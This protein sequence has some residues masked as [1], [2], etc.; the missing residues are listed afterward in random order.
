MNTTST[1]DSDPFN[2]Q[3]LKRWKVKSNS[4]RRKQ[5]SKSAKKDASRKLNGPSKAVKKRIPPPSLH[6]SPLLASSRIGPL[7]TEAPRRKRSTTVM[8]NISPIMKVTRG[9]VNKNHSQHL[10][11][12]SLHTDQPEQLETR[13]KKPLY[14]SPAVRTERQRKFLRNLAGTSGNQTESDMFNDTGRDLGENEGLS[15]GAGLSGVQP[16]GDIPTPKTRNVNDVN[17]KK[18]NVGSQEQSG[19][20]DSPFRVNAERD[21]QEMEVSLRIKPSVHCT[22][23]KLRIPLN[24]TESGQEKPVEISA[25]YTD[26]NSP[27]KEQSE[28]H[29]TRKKTKSQESFRNSLSSQSQ[30]KR[31]QSSQRKPSQESQSKV[32][33]HKIIG[34]SGLAVDCF[35]QG[36][37]AGVRYYLL[38]HFHRDH[39]QG[40]SRHW[41]HPLVCS[42][43]TRRLLTSKLKVR[44]SLIH[45]LDVGET[46]QFGESL[47]TAMD[48]NHCPGSVM[49]LI[50]HSG[51]TLLHTGDFRASPE[52]ESS[53]EFW[54]WDFRLSRLYLDTTYCRPQYDFPALSDVMDK[55][56]RLVKSFLASKPNTVII[57]GAYDVGKEKL[58]KAV[59]ESLDCKVWTDERRVSTWRC[60]EDGQLLARLVGDRARA[61]VLVLPNSLLTW[62]RLGLE[63]ERLT[64]SWSHVLGVRPTGWSH[65]RGVSPDS[66]LV[67]VAVQTR[68]DV[69][70]LEVP[71][72][73]HSSYT[74]LQRFVKFLGLKSPDDIIDIVHKS[75]RQ[76]MITKEIFSK[77]IREAQ[78]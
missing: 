8:S 43:V 77:W 9:R 11:H 21:S 4:S 54:Q 5:E 32:P 23:V 73:E 19:S 49:F 75:K 64:G 48:A 16:I 3:P 22:R 63:L 72:S 68:G 59:L 71:Y 15:Q 7:Q 67:G 39:L 40:L 69:S 1:F 26:I 51:Q 74:E 57:V 41:R 35:D 37:V 24:P 42:S 28:K 58:V 18:A 20:S 12:G 6:I 30:S 65:S 46:K 34:K 10:S 78:N 76:R 55:T 33:P 66:S 62:P 2:F 61:Q 56:V 44:D 25:N 38:S 70:L 47:V 14:D 60:L 52:M 29:Q 50:K 53:P 36:E 31:R 13:S 45:T 27:S 17:N